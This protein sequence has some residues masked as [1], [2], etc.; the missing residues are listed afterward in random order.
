MKYLYLAITISRVGKRDI[1]NV[2]MLLNTIMI[3]SFV[4]VTDSFCERIT[5]RM[6]IGEQKYL[7]DGLAN[8]NDE[9][10][11]VE[12]TVRQGKNVI[13]QIKAMAGTTNSY[14]EFNGVRYPLSDKDAGA[15]EQQLSSRF[16]NILKAYNFHQILKDDTII[17]DSDSL[18][19]IRSFLPGKL[20][21]TYQHLNGIIAKDTGE[22]RI[23]KLISISFFSLAEWNN[24]FH[25][26]VALILDFL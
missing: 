11:L 10:I 24:C 22:E 15:W 2:W 17:Y 16:K 20:R 18:I 5:G 19:E 8:R 23:G 13:S 9:H 4:F 7:I 25:D 26:Y 3:F 1:R 12:F 21:L 14:F 6:V